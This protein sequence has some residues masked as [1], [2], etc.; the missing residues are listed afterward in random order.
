MI[1][2]GNIKQIIKSRPILKNVLIF[3]SYKL[4]YIDIRILVYCISFFSSFP[5]YHQGNKIYGK[6]ECLFPLPRFK[7]ISLLPTLITY[8]VNSRFIHQLQQPTGK[9]IMSRNIRL[10]SK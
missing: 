10:P 9:Q 6:A 1:P 7:I 4:F 2:S 8:K 3:N 5:R